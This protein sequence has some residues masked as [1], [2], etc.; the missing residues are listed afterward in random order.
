MERTEEDDDADIFD[1]IGH[2]LE[3][4]REEFLEQTKEI[5]SALIK[6]RTV[7]KKTINSSTL[8]LPAWKKVV[9]DCELPAKI[10]PRDMKTRW[11]STYD[12]II[13]ALQY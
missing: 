5:C 8:L 3:A 12:M 10:L 11:N 13:A 4:E 9:S 2:M 6:V 1:E 7:A